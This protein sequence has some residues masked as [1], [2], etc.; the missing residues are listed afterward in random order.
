MHSFQFQ[1]KTILL[2]SP[3]PWGHIFVSKHHYAIELA[4]RDNQVF[5]LNPPS[6]EFKIQKSEFKNLT[7]VDYRGFV[8]GMSFFPLFIRKWMQKIVYNKI[9]KICNAEMDIVWSFDNS[10]FYDFDFLPKRVLKISH[11]VDYNMDYYFKESSESADF[12]FT[13]N[14]FVLDK[15]L[16]Y[17]STAH[18][19]NHGFAPVTASKSFQIPDS[20]GLKIGYAGNLDIKY[21]DWEILAKAIA[22]YEKHTFYFAGSCK[23]SNKFNQWDN[24][25]YLGKLNKADLR[26][27][28][29][30]MDILIIAYKADEEKEQLANPHKM[31]E[32]LGSGNPIVSTYTAAYDKS[33]LIYMTDENSEWTSLLGQSVEQIAQVDTP[34][35]R[36]ERKRFAMD[37]TYEKQVDRIEKSVSANE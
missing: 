7:I 25:A 27:F 15:L 10:V 12:C 14:Q 23:N 13:P 22:I 16:L 26:T 28:L 31:M 21:I 18:F 19:I 6:G 20:Q 9:Q 33:G 4:K 5:F 3:E 32:Y 30:S 35:L 36:E 1:N 2:I 8:K 24:V 34:E 29:E 17:S 37:N 11:I